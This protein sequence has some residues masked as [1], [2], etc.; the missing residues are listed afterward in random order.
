M[1]EKNI[2]QLEQYLTQSLIGLHHLFDHRAVAEIMKTPTEDTEFFSFE[3]LGN[4]QKL[5]DELLKRDTFAAKKDFLGS[6]DPKSYE[7]LL[8]TYFHILDSTIISASG[9]KH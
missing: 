6:L 5:M 7:I 1:D 9:L 4:I 8:R 2:E 3:N